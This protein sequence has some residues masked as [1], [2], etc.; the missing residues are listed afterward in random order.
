MHG[1]AVVAD[2]LPSQR[3]YL[4]A[5]HSSREGEEHRP[6]DMRAPHGVQKQP[7]LFDRERHHLETLD[8]RLP[9]FECL[10]RVARE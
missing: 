3:Q 7:R 2:I 1:A 4:A 9:L 8:A 6:V 10:G 5:S